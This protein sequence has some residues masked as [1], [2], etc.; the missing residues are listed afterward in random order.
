MNREENLWFGTPK[1]VIMKKEEKTPILSKAWIEK[2]IR[3]NKAHY[4]AQQIA[5]AIQK[6]RDSLREQLVEAQREI[7]K[8]NGWREELRMRHE[9]LRND[10]EC[11]R[12]DLAAAREAENALVN[13]MP[14]ILEDYKP[15]QEPPATRAA[16]EYAI[17]IAT[18][19]ANR[20]ALS[21]QSETATQLGQ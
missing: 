7:T 9:R 12:A 20:P 13:L 5:D 1:S 21:T 17:K 10:Y 11:A 18:K 4:A 19:A 6:E 2:V 8:I 16:M 14:H 15:K 3:N